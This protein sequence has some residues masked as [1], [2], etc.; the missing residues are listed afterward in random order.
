MTNKLMTTKKYYSN[1]SYVLLSI[2]FI[3]IFGPLLPALR[4][5]GLHHKMI[6]IIIFMAI[7]YGFIAHMFFNTVYT[8]DNDK[9]N[10]K[11]GFFHYKPIK[12][13]EIKKIT[14]S[15]NIISSPAAS[16]DRIEISYGKFQ[17]VIISPKDKFKFAENLLKINP[18]IVN[19]LHK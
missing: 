8:I 13:N 1:V 6:F 9:L 3:V 10:I 11:C 14:K 19:C 12:I 2:V 5:D 17:E 4:S 18:A 16:F 7:F 15:T